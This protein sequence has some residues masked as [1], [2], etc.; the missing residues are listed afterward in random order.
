MDP[1]LS[2]RFDKDTLVMDVFVSDISVTGH[3]YNEEMFIPSCYHGA[4][5]G[6]PVRKNTSHAPLDP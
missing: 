6:A 5:N 1:A 4:V 3:F 2:R